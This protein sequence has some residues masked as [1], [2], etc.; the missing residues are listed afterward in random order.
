VIGGIDVIQ[1][2]ALVGIRCA[3]VVRRRSPARYSRFVAEVL[4]AERPAEDLVAALLEFAERKE[5]PPV[6]FY[7]ADWNL[8]L[9][10]QF[11][12]RLQRSFRFVL[13]DGELVE[14]LVDKS[15]FQALAAKL[16]LP[17]PRGQ[18]LPGRG[19]QPGRRRASVSAP[20]EAPTQA[21][22]AANVRRF[23]ATLHASAGPDRLAVALGSGAPR[24]LASGKVPDKA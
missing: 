9:V 19:F 2:L 21:D 1:P 16:E 14:N 20:F 12:D 17:V 18:A 5:Q 8:R 22:R 3:A 7:S 13:P 6:L 24:Q 4:D 10:S 23:R 11:R 15:R